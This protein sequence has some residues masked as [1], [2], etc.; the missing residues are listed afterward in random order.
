MKSWRSL[1]LSNCVLNLVFLYLGK[2]GES[3]KDASF[4][5]QVFSAFISVFARIAAQ[6]QYRSFQEVVAMIAH[7]LL[8]LITHGS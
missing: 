4:I 3:K 1:Q 8:P 2:A 6:C 7:I 5:G